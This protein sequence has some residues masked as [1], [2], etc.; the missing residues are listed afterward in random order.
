MSDRDCLRKLRAACV[1]IT[2]ALVT[3]CASVAPRLVA[4]EIRAV[5]VRVVVFDFPQVRLA[6]DLTVFNPNARPIGLEGLDVA[7]HVE[8]R[9]VARTSLAA[10]V[11]LA[12]SS[13]T[14][15][16]M[17]ATGHLGAALAGVARSL[18]RGG[19]ALRYEIEGTARLADGSQYPFRRSGVLA[20]R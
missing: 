12:P 6:M 19:Q 4:P 13:A 1:A 11:M 3:A 16:A 14:S 8:G 9:P 10:P 5:E 20:Y 17:D 15:V 18:D 2:C 7:L